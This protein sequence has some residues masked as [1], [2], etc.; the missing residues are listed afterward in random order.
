[1]LMYIS[2]GWFFDEV[3]GIEINQILQYVNWVIY[4][5]WQIL[6]LELY[7]EFLVK[8]IVIYSNVYENGVVS[9]RES[10]M[11]VWVDLVWVGMYFVVFYLFEFYFDE[12]D[13][14]NYM[15]KSEIL[16]KKW[17]GNFILV[18]G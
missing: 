7:D 9:Y 6:N 18:L 14:F 4:Y 17:V 15:V 5:V 11:L 13:V 1:M 2:C 16:K 3:F 10:V 8:L 12:L